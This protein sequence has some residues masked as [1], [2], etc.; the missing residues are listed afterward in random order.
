[1]YRGIGA[2]ADHFGI[3]GNYPR[4]FIRNTDGILTR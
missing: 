1:M 3:A 2:G 4:F